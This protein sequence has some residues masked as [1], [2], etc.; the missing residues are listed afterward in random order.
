MRTQHRSQYRRFFIVLILLF[1]TFGI[2]SLQLDNPENTAFGLQ[3][4]VGSITIVNATVPAGGTGFFYFG[5]L[6]SFTLDDGQSHQATNVVPGNYDVYQDIP[7]G[8]QLDISCVGG[9]STPL[10]TGAVTIHLGAGEDIVCTFTN[11]DVAGSIT[12]VNATNP[13]GA[14]GFGFWG[15]IGSFMLDDGQSYQELNLM[16]GDYNIFETVPFS[17]QLGVSCTGGDFTPLGNEAVTVHLDASEDI[18]CTFTNTNVGGSITVV[19]ATD[20]AGGTGFFYFGDLGSFTLDDGQSQAS[21]DMMPGDY[22]VFQDVPTGWE[23]SVSCTGGDFTPVGNSVTVHLDAGENIVCTFT[24]TYVGGSITLVNATNPAGATGFFYFGDLGNVTLDD[25]QSFTETDLL[26]GDYTV[27]Q[28]VPVGWQ[29]NI[30]CVGGGFTAVDN[31]VTVHLGSREDIVCTFSNTYIG[32]SVTVVNA[33]NPAG[34]T[35]F[36]YFGAFGDHLL[37]DGQSF[38]ETDLMPGD[39]AI[40]QDVPTGWIVDISCT[41]GDFTAVDNSVT[42]H[43]DVNEDIACTFS[44]TY[45]GG[46]VTILNATDPAGATDFFYFG[47]FGEHFLDDGQSFTEADMMP[48]DY[49]VFQDVPAGW[50]VEISCTG[51]DFTAVDNSVTVHLDANEDIVCTFA[52]TD[53]AGSITIVNATDPAGGTGFFYFGSLGEF[54]LDDG[55]SYP[56]PSLMPGDYTVFQDVPLDWTLDIACVGGAADVV[57][58]SV[59]IH[60]GANEEIVCTFTNTDNSVVVNEPPVIVFFDDFESDQGWTSNPNG[61]D[62]ATTGQ[63]LRGNPSTTYYYGVKQRGT[64]VSGR[65]NLVTGPAAGWSVGSYDVDNGETSV[66]SPNIALPQRDSITLSFYYYMAH[67]R[68]S[69]SDDYLRVKVVG[70]TTGTLLEELGAA[71]D[72]DAV[73]E[74]FSVDLSAYAGQTVYLLIEAADAAGGSIVEAAIDDVMIVASDAALTSVFFDDFSADQGWTSNPNGSDTATTGQWERGNPRSTSYYGPKQLGTTISGYNNLVTGAAS[75]RSVGSYDVD[76][77]ETSIRSADIVLPDSG[78]ISLSFYYYMAHTSNSSADDYFRVKVVGETT[79]L[80][81]EE[82][83]AANDDDAVWESFSAD[84]TNFAGQTVYLLIE[85]SDAAAGSIVEAAIDDVSIVALP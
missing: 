66:R 25:G 27:F 78:Y 50:I 72:D 40:F 46:S 38:T 2:F 45:V 28:D 75:G 83:G 56:E 23:L 52:N 51:G 41:G 80:V 21:N 22:A 8:W 6:G 30:S 73:W 57:N 53:V 17:W 47:D 49:T 67:T 31:S 5:S 35:D 29:L 14:T 77:G 54:T 15:D 82:L 34:A 16:P 37:D 84:L 39:Y 62:T 42:I 48:G 10:G 63:W 33:T 19:N 12:I 68:N 79:E 32:G 55:Q 76:N 74:S 81:L 7:A 36:F 20:P 11:T 26:P 1:V 13:P 24:N 59:A 85:T 3:T 18:V 58:N 44:N 71:N 4:E 60:L 9:S 64:T 61:S 65:Y 43:L 70:A 69:S